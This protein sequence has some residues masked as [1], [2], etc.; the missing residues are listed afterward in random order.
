M[1]GAAI[2]EDTK[3]ESYFIVVALMVMV[4]VLVVMTI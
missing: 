3:Y 1:I 2:I 4:V